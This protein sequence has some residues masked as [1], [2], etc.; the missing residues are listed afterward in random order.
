MYLS[1][2]I[3]YAHTKCCTYGLISLPL[4]FHNLKR[5][6]ANSYKQSFENIYIDKIKDKYRG[7]AISPN[8]ATTRKPLMVCKSKVIIDSFPCNNHILQC[9]RDTWDTVQ[10]YKHLNINA[11]E[12]WYKYEKRHILK[13]FR[14]IES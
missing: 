6:T 8:L 14:P 5:H 7:Y 9:K 13:Y 4:F 1:S 3:Y 10:R 11:F 12:F 2:Y